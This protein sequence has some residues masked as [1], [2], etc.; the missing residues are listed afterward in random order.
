VA[1]VFSRDIA[2]DFDLF[3][4]LRVQ[5]QKSE[6][7]LYD[8]HHDSRHFR[9]SSPR[10]AHPLVLLC[11]AHPGCCAT[12][13]CGSIG[14]VIRWLFNLLGHLGFLRSIGENSAFCFLLRGRIFISSKFPLS[15]MESSR[16]S[17]VS[18]MF[19]LRVRFLDHHLMEHVILPKY[20][21]LMS[22]C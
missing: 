17:L 5:S 7:L 16:S 11:R 14:L 3:T 22:A 15:K 9:T 10:K 19:T 6:S 4:R 21:W 18:I 1:A 2:T 12:L 20:K 8:L 13:V